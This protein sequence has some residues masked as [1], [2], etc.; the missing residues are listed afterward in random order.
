MTKVNRSPLGRRAR[1]GG[2]VAV[3]LGAVV[4]DAV[5]VAD[6]DAVAVVEGVCEGLAMSVGVG[7]GVRGGSVSSRL[8]VGVAV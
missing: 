7:D 1:Q 5:A 3:G 8:V 2:G 6:G 4:A